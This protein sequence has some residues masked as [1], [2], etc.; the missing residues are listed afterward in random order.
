MPRQNLRR[1]CCMCDAKPWQIGTNFRRYATR[2]L[3]LKKIKIHE[4]WYYHIT[5]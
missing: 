3:S 2:P 4:I 1:R 5:L